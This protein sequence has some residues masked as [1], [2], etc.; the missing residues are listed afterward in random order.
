M[1][2]Q[3][4]V[5]TD[6]V[7][8]S[9]TWFDSESVDVKASDGHT[10]IQW[11]DDVAIYSNAIP[12]THWHYYTPTYWWPYETKT[13]IRMTLSEIEH[14]RKLCKNDRKLRESMQKLAPHIEVEVD[15]LG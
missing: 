11:S 10:P 3:N 14:I 15:F 13:K 4:A 6:T 2:T 8:L 7:H 12:A 9:A 1:A 5:G